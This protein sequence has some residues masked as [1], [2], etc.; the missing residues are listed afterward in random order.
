MRTNYKRLATIAFAFFLTGCSGNLK[1][2]EDGKVHNGKYDQ[3]SKAITIDIDGVPYSGTY[4]QGVT[5]GF[6]TAFAGS[7]V[8]TGSMLST[9]GSG[10]ALL[11]SPDGKILRCVFGPVVGWRGQGQCQNNQGRLFDLLIGG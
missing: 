11:T 4:V 10:Q 3:L 9:N 2:L 7:K 1:L 5:T 8:V 6:G